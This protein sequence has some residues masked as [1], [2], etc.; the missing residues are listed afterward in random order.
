MKDIHNDTLSALLASK[1]NQTNQRYDFAATKYVFPKGST[2]SNLGIQQMFI[3]LN[4]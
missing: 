3:M 1:I 4:I 2:I